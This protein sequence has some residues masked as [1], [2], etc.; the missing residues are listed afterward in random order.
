LGNGDVAYTGVDLQL[1]AGRGCLRGIVLPDDIE[2][3]RRAVA[4]ERC[5]RQVGRVG[6]NAVRRGLGYRVQI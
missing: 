5:D 1:I 3:R 4:N 6:I 2:R